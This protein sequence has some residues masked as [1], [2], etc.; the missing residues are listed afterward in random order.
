MSRTQQVVFANMCMIYDDNGNV[1]VLDRKDPNWS[2]VSFPGGHV[3][4]DESFIESVIREVLEETGLVIKDP[5]LCGIKQYRHKD[6]FRYI[7]LLFKTN[8]FYGQIKSSDEGE[9]FWV[10]RSELYN[11]KLVNDFKETLQVFENDNLSE[12]YFES[13]E[14]GE[15]ELKLL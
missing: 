3:E 10:K 5:Q 2:G 12:C 8:K 1:L 11:Y 7:V 4:Q 13:I 15:W 14:D 6:G 9:V